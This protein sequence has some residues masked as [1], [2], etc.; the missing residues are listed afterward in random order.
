MILASDLKIIRTSWLAGEY[1]AEFR[2]DGIDLV[3]LPTRGGFW[4]WRWDCEPAQSAR[5][6]QLEE[7]TATRGECCISGAPSTLCLF[8]FVDPHNII[9]HHGSFLLKISTMSLNAQD[10]EF[11]LL[12]WFHFH[13]DL[14]G[15][16]SGASSDFSRSGSPVH[17]EA[18]TCYWLHHGC[19]E[20]KLNAQDMTT[21]PRPMPS[22]DFK[23]VL[24]DRTQ[25]LLF[26][27][28]FF[29]LGKMYS[30]ENP[31]CNL[32]FISSK[33]GLTSKFWSSPWCGSTKSVWRL[34]F[35]SWEQTKFVRCCVGASWE[36]EW[37]EQKLQKAFVENILEFNAVARFS[38]RKDWCFFCADVAKC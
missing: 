9:A 6:C 30:S 10:E 2:L 24:G 25:I 32:F 27:F 36:N 33:N 12:T 26:F 18:S 22:T 29:C 31:E 16:F 28:F 8:A 34:P 19:C 5:V 37:T 17:F 35:H 13:V 38:D 23:K 3:R 14:C 11:W 15:S 4:K 7:Q 1:A 21:S 20:A